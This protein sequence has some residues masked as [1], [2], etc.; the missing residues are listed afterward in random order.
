MSGSLTPV[1]SFTLPTVGADQN[2]W[3]T[4]LNG[5]WSKLDGIL[6]T[7]ATPTSTV[8]YLPLAG[9]QMV[10]PLYLQSDPTSAMMAATL[11]WV[12]NNFVKTAGSSTIGG[13]LTV[14]GLT[15]NG[16]MATNTLNVG[17]PTINDFSMYI[18]SGGTTRNFNWAY[19]VYDTY[20]TSSAQWARTW[21]GT[22]YFLYDNTGNFSIL[23]QGYKPGGG[24][25]GSFS[26]D[27]VKQ[28]VKP[29]GAGLAE[30]VQLKP[31]AFEYNGAGGTP[32]DGKTYYGL[33]AQATRLVMPELVCNMPTM[34]T[35]PTNGSK[36]VAGQL[37][38]DLSALPMALIN[39]I[40]ELAERVTAL[41]EHGA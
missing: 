7:L 14:S 15:S 16:G 19:N 33:S 24:V 30:V 41:E 27:R 32:A 9:G 22:T 40:R 3:G 21:G 5:N 25:W 12:S 20:S 2:V 34:L 18:G 31:V 38:T 4:E 37:G 29:Y 28:N 26:D 8:Q 23:N 10:G 11:G 1:Y 35:T 6:H 36:R 13:Q 17:M 39:A